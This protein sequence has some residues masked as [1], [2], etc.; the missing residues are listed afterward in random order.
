ML[1]AQKRAKGREGGG[2]DVAGRDGVADELHGLPVEHWHLLMQEG[3]IWQQLRLLDV[4][5]PWLS[6][7]PLQ[8]H[9]C[10]GG[11]DLLLEQ[12]QSQARMML[13]HDQQEQGGQAQPRALPSSFLP[14]L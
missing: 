10:G 1:L 7:L 2:E 14:M 3:M 8:L 9:L 5:Q 6:P 11:G 13:K 12:G 4:E